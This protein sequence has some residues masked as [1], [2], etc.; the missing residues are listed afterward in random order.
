MTTSTRHQRHL[1]ERRRRLL[2]CLEIGIVTGLLAV[3]LLAL[4]APRSHAA[5]RSPH[6]GSVSPPGVTARQ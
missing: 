4:L 2:I 5:G 6:P 1:E 3:L